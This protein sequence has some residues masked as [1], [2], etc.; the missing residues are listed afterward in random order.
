MRRKN[1]K[2]EETLQHRRVKKVRNLAQIMIVL[3]EFMLS[4]SFGDMH[5]VSDDGACGDGV[6][7][8]PNE[9]PA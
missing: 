7:S 8:V 5:H 6:I 9:A 2:L 3:R 1:L 4:R